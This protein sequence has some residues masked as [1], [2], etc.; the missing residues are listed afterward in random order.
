M[1]IRV[2]IQAAARNGSQ[3][4][5]AV[6]ISCRKA[7]G[8][9]RVAVMGV[10]LLTQEG[11]ASL[12]QGGRCRTVRLVADSTIFGNRLMVM[13]KWP[14]L[15]HVAGV[16]SFVGAALDQGLRIVAVYVMARRTGH[17]P[18]DDRVVRRLIN[19]RTL[20][21][22]AGEAGLGLRNLTAHLVMLVMHLV[23]GRT[24]NVLRSVR[25]GL[26]TDAAAPLVTG[27]TSAVACGNFRFAFFAKGNFGLWWLV[28]A[29]IVDMVC[30][31]AVTTGAGWSATIG[32]YAMTSL[33]NAQQL[34]SIRFIVAARALG[35]AL[36]NDVL[37]RL[38]GFDRLGCKGHA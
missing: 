26:P 38:F 2:A 20:F 13:H 29:L 18:L 30:A 10:T 8:L 23:T 11:R 32:C 37:R 17:L 27:Q 1:N 33:A 15:F 14:A 9:A 16:T 36:Q 24:S 7:G 31:L 35:I 28:A 6:G 4:A 25:T 21:L 19:L 22:V 12:E 3:R 5:G 34:R